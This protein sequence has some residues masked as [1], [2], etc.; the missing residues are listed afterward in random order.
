[1]F[2]FV[3]IGLDPI[4]FVV[5]KKRVGWVEDPT[6]TTKNNRL[7]LQPNLRMQKTNWP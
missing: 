4:I 3:I 6:K 7:G 5:P 2:D 1:M